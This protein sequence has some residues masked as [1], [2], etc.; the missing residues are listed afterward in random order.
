ML[1]DNLSVRSTRKYLVSSEHVVS[2]F[3]SREAGEFL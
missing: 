2:P 1:E 3:A